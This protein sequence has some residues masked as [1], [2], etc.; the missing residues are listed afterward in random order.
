MSDDPIEDLQIRL[1][2]QELTIEAL[3][4]AVSRQGR[5]LLELQV[6]VRS[7]HEQLKALIPSPL[8]EGSA[9]EPPPP[10]Y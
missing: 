2:H 9:T 4:E 5:L 8:G 6:E 3:N 7:L 1:A 10:H